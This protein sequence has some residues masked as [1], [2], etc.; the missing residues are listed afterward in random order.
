MIGGLHVV[1]IWSAGFDGWAE[2]RAFPPI[3]DATLE[4]ASVFSFF[5]YGI[6]ICLG[7]RRGCICMWVFFF[8]PVG[9]CL[10]WTWLHLSQSG[11]AKWSH[12]LRLRQSKAFI[13]FPKGT[14]FII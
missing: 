10:L 11:S 2:P 4:Q 8:P 9:I 14:Y 5:L 1:T 3:D 13:L 12:Y 7:E 6:L